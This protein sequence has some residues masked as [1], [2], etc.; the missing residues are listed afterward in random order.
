LTATAQAV[1]ST[2]NQPL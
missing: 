2:P 1:S